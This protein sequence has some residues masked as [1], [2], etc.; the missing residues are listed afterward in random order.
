MSREYVSDV[1]Y[2]LTTR[3][4]GELLRRFGI[5]L[6]AV[7]PE[8]ADTPFGERSSAGKIFG[9]SGGVMEAAMRTPTSC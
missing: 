1:D 5:D 3:E 9:A 8:L 7:E 6:N 2:V 4:L